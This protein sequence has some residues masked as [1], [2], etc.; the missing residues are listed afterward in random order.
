MKCLASGHP[1]S[2]ALGE[3]PQDTQHRNQMAKEKNSTVVSGAGD[4]IPSV[5]ASATCKF[6]GEG[7]ANLVFTLTGVDGHPSFQGK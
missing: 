1:L 7:R 4:D 6:V 5:P 3:A 2:M